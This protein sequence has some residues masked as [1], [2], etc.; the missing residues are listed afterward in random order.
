MVAGDQTVAALPST[1]GLEDVPGSHVGGRRSMVPRQALIDWYRRNR[2]RTKALFDLVSEEAYYRRPI[3][4]RHPIVFYEGHLPAFSFNTLVKRALGQPG[5]DARLEALFA[6]GIDPH[7]SEQHVAGR[8]GNH[9]G[10]WPERDTLQQFAAEA[11]RQ[12][13]DALKRA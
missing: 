8:A 11:D 4:L 13:L 12:V 10:G 6:R 2:I 1:R 5:I 9:R 3:L 7:E